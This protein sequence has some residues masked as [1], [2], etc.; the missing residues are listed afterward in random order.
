MNSTPSTE[1]GSRYNQ[2]KLPVG[3]V[4]PEAIKGMAEVLDFGAQKYA[5][6]NWEKGMSWTQTYES[7]M[8]HLLA[9][10]QGEDR[11]PESGL[12]HLHHV[13]CNAAFLTTFNAR[14]IGTDDRP[15]LVNPTKVRMVGFQE[16]A[17]DINP[18]YYDHLKPL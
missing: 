17:L 10:F 6:R 18:E 9:W 15:K 5:P 14:G 7:L 12:L 1:E 2:G 11:D 8:R 16:E 13:L 3:L 4:P